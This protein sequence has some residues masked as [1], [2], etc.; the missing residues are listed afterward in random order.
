MV[1]SRVLREFDNQM[2]DL[3]SKEMSARGV[4]FLNGCV[5]KSFEK[6]SNGQ[7]QANW[8]NNNDNKE[9]SDVFDT[10]LMASGR[11]A[12]TNDL[13]VN[14]AG[15]IVK[16]NQKIEATNEQTNVENIYAVGDVL[17]VSIIF[18]S[19]HCEIIFSI[20]ISYISNSF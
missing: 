10:V 17:Y 14:N 16:E 4:N 11:Y 6:Q 13:D 1:R 18:F 8:L 3:I 19:I 7:I 2:G 15:L 5:P 12:C 20:Y 9:Y